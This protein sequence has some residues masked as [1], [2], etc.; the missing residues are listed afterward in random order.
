MWANIGAM[1]AEAGMRP[2]DV[3]SVTPTASGKSL[4]F[5]LPVLQAVTGGRE[6]PDHAVVDDARFLALPAL[7]PGAPAARLVR[8]L[9]E[10]TSRAGDTMTWSCGMEVDEPVSFRIR[11]GVVDRISVDW[12]VD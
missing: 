10:P 5:N 9:G 3:V 2:T 6:I 8:A 4:C 11:G 1:L 7:G 12:Y